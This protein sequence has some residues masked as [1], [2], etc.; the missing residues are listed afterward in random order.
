MTKTSAL[1]VLAPIWQR[2]LELPSIPVNASFFDLGGNLSSATRLFAEIGEAT[3]HDLSPVLIYVAPTI[4]TLAA[5]LEQPGPPRIPPLLLLKAGT[6]PLPVFIAHGIGGTV[7]GFVDLLQKIRF[8][9]AIY[10]MEASGIDGVSEPLTSIETMAELYLDAIKQLQPHGPYFLIGYS[11]GGLV[12]L[13][14]A[15]RLL[16]AG[17]K[18]GLLAMVETYPEKRH[19]AR[20]QSWLLSFRIARRRA[21]SFVE[22]VASGTRSHTSGAVGGNLAHRTPSEISADRLRRRIVEAEYLA[23]KNYCP[24]FYPGTIKFVRAGTSTHFPND[25]AAVWLQLAAKL[26][27]ETI[28][29]DH[30][31]ILETNFEKLAS[32]LTRYMREADTGGVW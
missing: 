25:A 8:P 14:I 1:E 6:E 27:V 24:R 30:L 32:V 9:H 21:W 17:E 15:Q 20:T 29:G 2:V 3:G 18:V 31:G 7:F 26:E 13:E 5:V 16:A 28:P 11:L 23:W 4:E 22:S 10:G 19:L 12:T